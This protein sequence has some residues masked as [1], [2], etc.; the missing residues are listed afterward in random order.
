MDWKDSA[1]AHLTASKGKLYTL[2]G[3]RSV[4]L[5]ESEYSEDLPSKIVT[6]YDGGAPASCLSAGGGQ[7]AVLTTDRRLLWIRPSERSVEARIVPPEIELVRLQAEWGDGKLLASDAE[8]DLYVIDGSEYRRLEGAR[9]DA[10]DGC[11]IPLDRERLLL[12]GRNDAIVVYSVREKRSDKLS[13]KAASIR[14]RMFQAAIT[15]GAVL[16]DGTVVVG[17]R[18]GMLFALAPDLRSRTV[19]GRLYS[20]GQLR[21]F[22]RI[23]NDEVLGI[24]GG[25]KEAGHVFHFSRD[26]GFVDLG[27]PR[28]IKDNP[29]LNGSASEFGNIH[30]ISRIAYGADDDCLHAA[31]AELYGCVIRYRGVAFPE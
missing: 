6:L 22:I 5:T 13:V 30:H 27:R 9:L 10:P 23:G 15:G 12:S 31:S 20:N 28:M 19:Y 24:Y 16:S 1:V 17:T 4:I 7:A 2:G 18:D 8:G 21:D 26:R 14:G 25:E 11:A 3:H 29:E